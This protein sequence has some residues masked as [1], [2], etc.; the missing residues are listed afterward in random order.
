[1]TKKRIGR[2]GLTVGMIF[3]VLFFGTGMAVLQCGNCEDAFLRCASDP[4][5]QAVTF[6]VTY[7]IIG[8]VFCLKYIEG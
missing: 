2:K 3:L 8:Y 6:G 5:W 1:M 7:C 4:Y